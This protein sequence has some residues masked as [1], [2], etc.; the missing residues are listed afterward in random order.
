MKQ[1]LYLIS[2]SEYS[3]FFVKAQVSAL[4]KVTN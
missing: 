1:V 2:D 4:F 3:F